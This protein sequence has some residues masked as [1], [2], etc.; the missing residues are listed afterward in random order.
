MGPSHK[1]VVV[2]DN[3][4][5]QIP[6]LSARNR[7]AE[8]AKESSA[9]EERVVLRGLFLSSQRYFLPRNDWLASLTNRRRRRAELSDLQMANRVEQLAC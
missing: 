1:S 4:I 6:L 3:I 9:A 8:E 7:H 2:G 5:E